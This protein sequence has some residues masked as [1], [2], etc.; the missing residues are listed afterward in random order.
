MRDLLIPGHFQWSEFADEAHFQ[1]KKAYP[2]ADGESR[3]RRVPP[4]WL[5]ARS[6]ASSPPGS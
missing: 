6:T 1:C 2:G 5:P 3:R 4:R